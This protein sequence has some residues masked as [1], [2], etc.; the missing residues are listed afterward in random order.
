ME[1]YLQNG[2]GSA[3]AEANRFLKYLDR[4]DK[5][6]NSMWA[7]PDLYEEKEFIKDRKINLREIAGRFLDYQDNEKLL[8]F[9]TGEKV[10]SA[11]IVISTGSLDIERFNVGDS[12]VVFGYRVGEAEDILVAMGIFSTDLI[13][14][15]HSVLDIVDRL[16]LIMT[17]A[18]LSAK[19]KQ[20]IKEIQTTEN[21]PLFNSGQDMYFRTKEELSIRYQLTKAHYPVDVQ[22]AI[23]MLFQEISSRKSKAKEKLETIL[24]ISPINPNRVPID[25]VELRRLL[26]KK[27]Y[28]MEAAKQLIIDYLVSNEQAKKRGCS[29]LFVGPPGVGKTTLAESIAKLC[30]MPYEIIPMNGM[31][32]NL[33][34]IGSDSSYESSCP[35]RFIQAFEKYGTSEMV[36]ILD[37]IDK[38]KESVEGDPLSCLYRILTGEQ[39]DKFLEV[40]IPT[41]HTVFIATA[42]RIDTIPDALLN[43]F[44]CIIHLDGYSMEEK[45]EIATNYVIPELLNNLGIKPSKVPFSAEVLQYLIRNYCEDTGVRA[46]KHNIEI[47]L[48]HRVSRGDNGKIEISVQ[49]VD[50]IIGPLINPNSYGLRFNRER[51]RYGNVVAMEIEKQLAIINENQS[52]RGNEHDRMLAKRKLDYLLAC[53][54]GDMKQKEFSPVSF[55]NIL[56]REHYGMDEVIDTVTGFYHL[57]HLSGGMTETNLALAGGIG[58]GKT[59]ICKQIAAAMGYSFCKIPLNGIRDIQ[60]LR[61]FGVGYQRH[62]PGKV[63]KALKEAGSMMTVIQLDEI[64]K[65]PRELSYVLIDLLDRQFVENFLGITLDLSQ[66]IF[67]A[68]CNDWTAV[69]P[70]IRDRFTKVSVKG[71]NR[72]EK[73]EILEKYI[74]PKLEKKYASVGMKIVVQKEAK[75]LLLE[76]YCSSFGVRDLEKAMQKLV[77]NKATEICSSDSQAEI[78]INELDI[79]KILGNKP[80][81]RGNFPEGRGCIG[82]AKALAVDATNHGS[83]FSIEAMV[84]PGVTGNR[85]THQVTGLPRE[86]TKDSIKIAIAYIRRLYPRI[87]DDNNMYIHLGEGGVPKDGPS[88]GVAIAMA[89]LSAITKQPLCYKQPYDIAFT[90]EID[91]FG[92]IY[93]VGGIREKILAAVYSG[94]KKVYIPKQNY[95]ALGERMLREFECEIIAVNN[96]MDVIQDVWGELPGEYFIERIYNKDKKFPANL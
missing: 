52:Q 69:D 74:I 8:T 54:N 59:S 12:I 82:V 5:E 16:K 71:Y 25:G 92:G 35:G 15:F 26:D 95:D 48:R 76:S 80:I 83:P 28:R 72:A 44:H 9:Q 27:L 13:P 7:G 32:R 21:Y 42:N 34:L 40:K 37:E 73:E 22:A 2:L 10:I 87:M 53:K 31:D 89:L 18:R 20:T 77:G 17:Y 68:T 3:I 14:L 55:A 38:T 29:L 90:G 66:T 61:G 51:E 46:L 39:E 79:L 93:A 75:K 33:E 78:Q 58:T 70:I 94:C 49:D 96:L 84:V 41:E 36:C 43:R 86:S 19:K 85:G 67:I 64:D 30:Q 4:V 81:P 88:A 62:E 23:E 45:V 11:Y 50:Q 60:E 47:I 63:V 57:L 24:N 65:L 6:Q 56:R 1:E 91:L